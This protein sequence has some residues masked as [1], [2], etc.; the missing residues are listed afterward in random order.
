MK[1]IRLKNQFL[2]NGVISLFFPLY[3]Q[4]GNIIG[5]YN[6]KKLRN[7]NVSL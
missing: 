2:S 7:K 1:S 3:P 5:S 6:K 4:K